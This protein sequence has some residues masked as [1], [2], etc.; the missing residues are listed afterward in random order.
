MVSSVIDKREGEQCYLGPFCQNKEKTNI[1][2]RVKIK[3]KQID[4]VT[5]KIKRKHIFELPTK[6]QSCE[7]QE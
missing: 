4:H 1:S 7:C 6:I 5:C 2:R 3:R